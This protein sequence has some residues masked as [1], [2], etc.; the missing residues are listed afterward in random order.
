M[1]AGGF[2]V[3]PGADQGQ[4]AGGLKALLPTSTVEL[5]MKCSNL[6][7]KDLFSKSDPICVLFLKKAGQWYEIG[8]TEVIQVCLCFTGWVFAKLL[9]G[10]LR[11]SLVLLTLGGMNALL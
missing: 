11:I 8:R 1:S 2:A 6:S 4:G 7:D 10:F 9:K 5:S 3:G